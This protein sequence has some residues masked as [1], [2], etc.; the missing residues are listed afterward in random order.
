MGDTLSTLWSDKGMIRHHHDWLMTYSD[1]TVPGLILHGLSTQLRQV[2]LTAQVLITMRQARDT[3]AL[4][5]DDHLKFQGLDAN[6]GAQLMEVLGCEMDPSLPFDLP[7][8]YGT[9]ASLA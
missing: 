6:S 2:Y 5:T 7:S 4:S 8:K 1:E 9:V 3:P